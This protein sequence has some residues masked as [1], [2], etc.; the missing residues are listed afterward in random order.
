LSVKLVKRTLNK[1]GL[2][3]FGLIYN[4]GGS[5]CVEGVE[6]KFPFTSNPLELKAGGILNDRPLPCKN[7][8][9]EIEISLMA[10]ICIE[11]LNESIQICCINEHI[12]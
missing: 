2:D 11:A 9:M 5:F 7:Y 3:L 4:N 6:V 10:K 8:L 12:I 1:S